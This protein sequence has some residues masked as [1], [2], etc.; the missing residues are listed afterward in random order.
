MKRRTFLAGAAATAAVASGRPVVG[1]P[2]AT[3]TYWNGLTG[4]DGKVMDA[5]IDRFTQETGIRIEQQRLPW[6]DLYAKLQV[7]VPAGEGPD[8]ALIPP[9]GGPHL[10]RDG[11][12]EAV[13][14]RA[15]GAKG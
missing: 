1:Q 11:G 12:L 13:D 9:G 2:K 6:A 14:D 8:V 7:A 10:A 4:A 15:L 5:L 3:I